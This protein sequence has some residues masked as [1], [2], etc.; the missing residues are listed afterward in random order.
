MAGRPERPAP[1]SSA[2]R[3]RFRPS[4]R[5]TAIVGPDYFNVPAGNEVYNRG[6]IMNLVNSPSFPSGHTTYGYM[7]SLLLAVLVPDRYQEMVVARRG[8][9]QRPHHH[10]RALRHGCARRANR[11]DLRSCA[12]AR[13]R[14]AYIRRTSQ[15]R[16]SMVT[17]IEDFRAAV[18]TARADVTGARPGM[19]RHDRRLRAPGHWPLQHPPPM[20]PSTRRRRPMGLASHPECGASEDVGTLAPEAG[21]LLTVAFPALSLEEAN[22][23]LTETEGPAAAF[24]TMDRLSASIPA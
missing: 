13:Q 17:P 21:Y 9:R 15:H 18:A 24:S 23:I 2:I 4:P 14:S 20:K 16:N 11:R 12:S 22:R 6:P 10:G 3:A 1:T 5:V 7:G 8:I 19:R